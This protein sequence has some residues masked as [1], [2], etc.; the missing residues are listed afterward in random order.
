MDSKPIGRSTRCDLGSHGCFKNNVKTT[1]KVSNTNEAKQF[2]NEAGKAVSER[3]WPRRALERGGQDPG[4]DVR[5]GEGG[6]S[7]LNYFPGVAH[8]PGVLNYFPGG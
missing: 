2:H 1:R 6:P 4:G 7:V 3:R 8:T 5:G